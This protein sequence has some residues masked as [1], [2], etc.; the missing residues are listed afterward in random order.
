MPNRFLN[1]ITINDEYTFPNADGSANQVIATDGSGELS[2]VDQNVV[3][4]VK[5]V[6]GGS[7]SKGTVVHTAPSATPPSGNV[8]EV[9]AADYD[10]A[11]KMPAIGVLN[12]TIADGAEGAAVM[13]GA[14]SG[15]DTSSFSIGDELYVGN[16]GTFTNSKPSTAGQLIQKIAVVI[17]SHASNGLIK[18]FGAGR[19]ND[20]PLPLYID[21]TNQ[22]VGISEP[23]PNEKLVVSEIRTGSTPSDLYTTVVKSVQSAGATPNPGTGG[24]KVQYYDGANNHAFGLVAGTSSSDFLTTGPMHFY[25]NSD[26]DT[27]SATGF[28]MV[29]DSSQNVG[30]GVTSPTG[31]LHVKARA[32]DGYTNIVLQDDNGGGFYGQHIS[33]QNNSGTEAASIRVNSTPS[34]AELKL[35][36]GVSGVTDIGEFRVSS[37]NFSFRKNGNNVMLIQSDTNINIGMPIPAVNKLDVY[38]DIGIE[39]YIVHNGDTDTKFGFVANDN[40]AIRT[41]GGERVRVT[42]GGSVGINTNNPSA[43]LDVEGNAVLG[44][45]GNTATGS[46][47]V[48]LNQNNTANSLDS[49][50]TGE[51]TTASGRQSFSGGFN[52]TASGPGSFAIGGNSVAQGANSLCAGGDGT[53]TGASATSIGTLNDATNDYSFAAGYNSTASGLVSFAMG[54][55]VTA[56]GPKSTAFGQANNIAGELNFATGIS[57]T[58]NQYTYGNLISG[59]S[60]GTNGYSGAYQSSFNI[61]GG[62]Q[63]NLGKSSYATSACIAS[64]VV[65]TNNKVG[66]WDAGGSLLKANVA[67][68]NIV[69][70]DLNYVLGSNSIVVGQYNTMNFGQSQA[71]FG[72]GCVNP[73]GT[74]LGQVPNT[75]I[76]QLICGRNNA[77]FVNNST[78]MHLFAVG[79]GGADSS[80]FTTMNVYASTTGTARVGIAQDVP[81]YVLDVTGQARF[82][83][84]YTTSDERLKENIQ[85][86]TLGL[87]EL[88]QL[89]TVSYDWKSGKILGRSIEDITTNKNCRGLIA[90][91]AEIVSPDLV[92]TDDS[93]YGIKS[94]DSG[95]LTAMLIKSVQEQQD[96]IES[97]KERIQALENN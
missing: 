65:G 53:T 95:A 27:V 37:G 26:L 56:S 15:I 46:Y 63:N 41:A 83:G 91:E 14:V 70:G 92:D 47:A 52:T 77:K 30:I 18:I 76:P 85:D 28:A 22:R 78:G 67:Q 4:T 54:S 64:L 84:G 43:K 58:S 66:Y 12:E 73:G 82:T 87:S 20:V 7:L 60:N 45:S 13:M 71:I 89:R 25:T 97:L 23:S 48:A 68:G 50:A 8:I 9:I 32:S 1:N 17:K 40:F 34:A 59:N 62:I 72:V 10:D 93:E 16:L 21:N 96:I 31:D 3:I 90:Q 39:E 36:Y 55:G 61:G 51:N 94:I 19:S 75:S 86:N 33:F 88:K 79:N 44:S 69:G 5:N 42:S 80:R 2:F 49:L 74:T 35:Q 6:S 81:A 24:L 29:I 38:G 57:N 11:T